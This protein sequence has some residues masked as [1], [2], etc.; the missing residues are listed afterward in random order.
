M[1]SLSF[2]CF[3]E[4]PHALDRVSSS[5]LRAPFET[6]VLPPSHCLSSTHTMQHCTLTKSIRLMSLPL[7][8][9]VRLPI[10]HVGTALDSSLSSRILLW[11]MRRKG[12]WC[13]A[14]SMVQVACW[15][16]VTCAWPAAQAHASRRF[17]PY[18]KK[19]TSSFWVLVHRFRIHRLHQS[20]ICYFHRS[21]LHFLFLY[22][23]QI[24]FG[25]HSRLRFELDSEREIQ[26]YLVDRKKLINDSKSAA[27]GQFRCTYSN[28]ICQ[29]I[30]IEFLVSQSLR[31]WP[32]S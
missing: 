6:A 9:A 5:S 8:A 7:S 1:L 14:A 13:T 10:W 29:V 21:F 31:S 16:P 25:F 30:I 24:G 4:S 19:Q 32:S 3:P 12:S 23:D 22:S 26:K 28:D 20:L 18:H 27:D 2:P 15:L 17:D 11:E